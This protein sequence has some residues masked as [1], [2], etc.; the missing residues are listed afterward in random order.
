MT[1][2]IYKLFLHKITDLIDSCVE[3]DDSEYVCC[4]CGADVPL[5]Q[6]DHH[7]LDL[8]RHYC[9]CRI[10]IKFAFIVY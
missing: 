7:F 1:L 5:K 10:F 2:F 3:V 6:K 9:V 8:W 4:E